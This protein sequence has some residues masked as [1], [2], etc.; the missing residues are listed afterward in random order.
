MKPLACS[1]LGL[2]LVAAPVVAQPPGPPPPTKYKVTLRYSIQAPRDPHVAQYDAMIKHLV[3]IGFEF[4]PPLDQ[5]EDTDREDRTKNYLR[6][7]IAAANARKILDSLAVQSILLVPLAPD[8]FKLPDGAD[9]PVLVRLEIAGNFNAD[10]QRELQ[11]QVRVLLRELGFKEPV[12]YDHRA[13]SGRPYTRIAGT[14]PRGKLDILN[15]DL[16]LHPAGWLGPIMPRDELPLPLRD[17]NPV[18]VIEVLPDKDAAIKEIAEPEPRVP[19][20]LEKISPDLWE[21]VKDKDV[22]ARLTRVQVGFVGNVTAEDRD[23]RITLEDVTPGFFVEGQLGQ[24]VTG[25]IRLD[26]VKR[27]AAAPNVSVIRLPRVQHV[28]VEVKLQGDN[29]KALEQS[30]L[31]DLHKRGQRGQG[32]RIGIIDRD[33]RGWETLVKKKLLPAKT[34]LVDLTFDRDPEVYPMPFAGDPAAFGHGTMCAQAAALAAPDAEVVLIRVDIGD[35]YELYEIVRYTQS[36]RLSPRIEKQ[37][38]DLVAQG[39]LLKVRRAELLAERRVILNDFTDET[40]QKEFL[41]FLGPF[42]S[43]LYSDR[44]WHYQRMEQQEKLEEVHRLREER[45]GGHAREVASLKGI[46]ILV[47]AISWQSGFPLGG[48]S[49]LSKALDDP[50]GPLWF[51]AVGNTR[52]QNWVGPFRGVPGDPAMKFTADDTPLAKGRWSNEINFLDWQP[53]LGKIEPNLPEKTKLRLTL[54]W[55][56]PHD[57]D[58]FLRPGEPDDYRRPLAALRLQLL[59]QRDPATKSLPADMF[60]LVAR[61]AGWAQRL[62]HLPSGSVYEHVLEVPLEK[63]GRYAV[64]IEKQIDRYWVMGVHPVRKTPMFQVIEALTPTGIRPLGAPTLPALEKDWDLRPRLFVEVIDDENRVKGRAVFADFPTDAGSIGMPADARNVISVGAASLKNK[65]Q[66]YSAFGSPGGVELARRPWLYAYDELGL[67]DGSAYGTS[68]AN[69]FA[70]GTVAAMM[71]G[72]MSRPDLMQLLR[73]QEG[74]VLRTPK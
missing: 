45:F 25:L 66:P 31:K 74:Q 70:A 72:K 29:A 63:E 64:R 32:V 7:A 62:E 58:Y 30:G 3:K 8:E 22:P 40:D 36:G 50:K 61:T 67:A 5:H 10:R 39:A 34:R 56:E 65:P 43:W 46:P 12:G 20:F 4:D 15:R 37:F 55:R 49:P 48:I 19:E 53:H 26:H 71:S 18:Q 6:G 38:G 41:G 2:A 42:Y 11:N 73:E 1:L 35:P 27:L 9:D 16:R 28:N 60:E 59:R 14:I 17:V 51:Q 68:V 47:N 23:W 21:M 24:F 69:A 54:Q 13:P 44:E 57:P 52:G 33:F